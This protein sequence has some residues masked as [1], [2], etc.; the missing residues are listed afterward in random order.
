M[1]TAE[2]FLNVICILDHISVVFCFSK[3][4]KLLR[5]DTNIKILT[6]NCF[7]LPHYIWLMSNDPTVH[8]NL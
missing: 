2:F 1:A 6:L 7:S 5:N 8:Y 4:S 3:C